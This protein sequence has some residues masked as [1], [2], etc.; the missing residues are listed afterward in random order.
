MGPNKHIPDQ[1]NAY[2]IQK[3]CKGDMLRT[4]FSS[5]SEVDQIHNFPDPYFSCPKKN[6]WSNSTNKDKTQKMRVRL[7]NLQR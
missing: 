1:K 2:F 6:S 3:V 7:G 4:Y 5:L